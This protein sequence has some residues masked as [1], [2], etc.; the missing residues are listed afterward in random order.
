MSSAGKV[1]R[2]AVHG[3]ISFERTPLLP[4]PDL[5]SALIESEPVKRLARI[6]QLPFAHVQFPS[7]THTRLAH[8]I[9]TA[10]MALS[11][12]E[13]L[14][15]LGWFT[16]ERR[17]EL[18]VAFGVSGE[19][20]GI[21]RVVQVTVQHLVVAAL[22]QDLGELPSKQVLESFVSANNAIFDRAGDQF[23][24]GAPSDKSA[25]TLFQ[26]D[27]AL[28]RMPSH[29][30]SKGHLGYLV[31]GATSSQCET[32]PALR[33][34]R[35]ALAGVVDADRLD[36]VARDSYF[37]IGMTPASLIPDQVI[38]SIADVTED[39]VIVNDPTAISLFLLQRAVLRTEVF[40]AGQCRFRSTLLAVILAGLIKADP[41]LTGTLFGAEDFVLS[42]KAF[43]ALD[44]R[45]LEDGVDE[46]LERSSSLDLDDEVNHAI[47]AW[48]E[49]ER[50]HQHFW[51][52]HGEGPPPASPEREKLP[53]DVF[54]D[55]MIDIESH[56]L[57]EP[58]SVQL[59]NP[60]WQVDA[61]PVPLE[62]TGGHAA[63]FLSDAAAAAPVQ[64]R[65]LCFAPP[66]RVS[67]AKDLLGADRE[68]VDEVFALAQ[69]RDAQVR[70]T[71]P[72][73]TS[74]RESF[75][76]PVIF[77]SYCMTDIATVRRILK[78]LYRRRRKYQALL[79]PASGM[80]GDPRGNSRALA[81]HCGAAI[82]VLSREYVD[83]ALDA[84]SNIGIELHTLARRHPKIPVVAVTVDA[85]GDYDEKLEKNI[86]WTSFGFERSMFTG[87]ALRRANTA[88]VND[89]LDEA[90]NVIDAGAKR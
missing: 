5:I 9:G 85:Y 82:M 41:E 39:A 76:D 20:E 80:G 89:A 62:D 67:W 11:I 28:R 90:L 88:A 77:V 7:A 79:N 38:A 56:L 63:S 65:F 86:T 33:A 3:V 34:L 36:Y 16:S 19:V 78:V 81:E 57:Y 43:D 35:R 14:Y 32:V 4:N 18:E 53:L 31:T 29:D 27:Q 46:A 69:L 1:L 59:Q 71:V 60:S 83:R 70:L 51:L 13:R 49:S 42:G 44:D 22:L 37:T 47:E 61:A 68:S 73:D 48:R 50:D 12:A 74:A 6:L 58:G 2:D 8:S 75:A 87:P 30:L 40:F 64:G 84:S 25:F 66:D 72:D 10:H 26:I 23:G 52:P 55:T 21:D 54:V 45:R 17:A 15:A 24:I